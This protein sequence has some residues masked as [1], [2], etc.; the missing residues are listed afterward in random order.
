MTMSS[1]FVVFSSSAT[2][3]RRAFYATILSAISL[4][5]ILDAST[6]VT[7]QTA[8]IETLRSRVVDAV[9]GLNED[10]LRGF[11]DTEDDISYQSKAFLSLS[12]Q[13]DV[14]A[15]SNSKLAQYYAL[16]CVYHATNGVGNEIIDADAR[17]DNIAIPEWLIKSNWMNT[18]DVDPCGTSLITPTDL[19]ET[20]VATT[21]SRIYTGGWH[22]ITCDEEGR[23]VAIELYEN[24]LTGNFPQEVVLLAS[25][26]PFSTGAGS[27]ERLDLYENEFLS[28][29]GDSSWISDLGSNMTTIL[30]EGTGFTGDIPLL[31][32]NLV[33]F[34]IRNAYF[35]GGFIDEHFLLASELNYLNLDGNM[36]N[37]SIPSVLSELPNLEYLYMTDNFLVGDLSPLKGSQSLRE[38]WVD[39]N[40]GIG[41]PLFSW[42]GNMTTLASLSL[43]YNNLSGSIPT[44][45]G[46]LV[47][48]EQ[49]WLQFNN[50]TGKVPSELGLMMKLRHLELESNSLTGFVHS[51]ICEKTEFPSEILKTLGADCYDDNFFCPCCT[52]CDLIECVNG[53]RI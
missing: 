34:N 21:L 53:A 9:H 45:L 8:D 6:I 14:D 2:L 16:Y 19:Y 48:M 43:A 22:G 36:L 10:A 52:C 32:E 26:G 13:T 39:A 24:I 35:T 15:F 38:L 20:S 33:N 40:P 12:E 46:N 17:F 1:L 51:S 37:S 49:M 31:P 50:L 11:F 30:L 44:E 23:V 5:V 27:L 41:G 18:T 47:Y 42:L 7:A 3:T 29:G 28:N 25:D 4:L